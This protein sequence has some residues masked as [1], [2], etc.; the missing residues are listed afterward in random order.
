MKVSVSGQLASQT[1]CSG[2]VKAPKL[3]TACVPPLI[4]PSHLGIPMVLSYY[5][6]T[7]PP[8]FWDPAWSP[9]LCVL[10]DC[11]MAGLKLHGGCSAKCS[12]VSLSQPERQTIHWALSLRGL[13]AHSVGM[14]WRRTHWD[15]NT[16]ATGNRKHSHSPQLE[17]LWSMCW[18]RIE[19]MLRTSSSVSPLATILL[20]GFLL[21]KFILLYKSDSQ[22]Y[23][24][25][26]P[27][28]NYVGMLVLLY[29]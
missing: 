5:A 23:L 13:Y 7:L 11:F 8:V 20:P 3:Q 6:P 29:L 21:F 1:I 14:P 28:R 4:K 12:S 22:Y 24:L 25:H 16:L 9:G 17:V 27:I 26:Y 15:A 10:A 2:A 18:S 19:E